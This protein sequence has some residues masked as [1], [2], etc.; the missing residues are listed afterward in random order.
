MSS[1]QLKPIERKEI[2]E[3]FGDYTVFSSHCGKIA[4]NSRL[5][6]GTWDEN[7]HLF[8]RNVSDRFNAISTLIGAYVSFN[9]SAKGLPKHWIEFIKDTDKAL[10]EEQKKEVKN[11]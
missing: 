9:G 3:I 1:S 4:R 10:L 2:F 11:D 8:G 6:H 5:R 7:D